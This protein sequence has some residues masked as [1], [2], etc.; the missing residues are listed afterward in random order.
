MKL[1]TSK[2]NS[3]WEH[4]GQCWKTRFYLSLGSNTGQDELEKQFPIASLTKIEE[5]NL[6]FGL[7]FLSWISKRKM[8]KVDPKNPPLLQIQEGVFIKKIG[9]ENWEKNLDF[10]F[11]RWY[12]LRTVEKFF[13]F[14]KPLPCVCSCFLVWRRDERE[15]VSE[16]EKERERKGVKVKVKEKEGGKGKEVGEKGDMWG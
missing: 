9:V 2:T 6:V 16:K 7:F 13:I 1:N 15:L 10:K 5:Q 11:E 8:E 12:V 3:T 4:N 14:L